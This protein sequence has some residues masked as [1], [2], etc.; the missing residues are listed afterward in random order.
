MSG[1]LAGLPDTA[2]ERVVPAREAAKKVKPIA[3]RATLPSQPSVAGLV[4]RRT[5]Q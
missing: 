5:P 4:A 3:G 2:S 1:R